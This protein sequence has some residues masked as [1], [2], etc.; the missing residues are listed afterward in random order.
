MPNTKDRRHAGRRQPRLTA[1]DKKY[2]IANG[3]EPESF[4]DDWADPRDGFRYN[5][6]K[7]QIRSPNLWVMDGEEIIKQ[8]K[9]LKRKLKLRRAMKN[10]PEKP[11]RL[12]KDLL[13]LVKETSTQHNP[14]RP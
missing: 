13:R 3:L 14:S 7:T 9:K 4:W 8:N 10:E 11:K 2:L 1:K 5:L 12:Q 6:D